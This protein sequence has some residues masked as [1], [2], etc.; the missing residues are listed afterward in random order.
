MRGVIYVPTQVSASRDDRYAT[1]SM[2]SKSGCGEGDSSNKGT[3]ELLPL[4]RARG[5]AIASG[6]GGLRVCLAA[7]G[8]VLE[9]G[10]RTA[11]KQLQA[12]CKGT[13]P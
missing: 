13:D 1:R 8:A 4:S 9:N 2:V 11:A 3:A 6:F 12:A 5:T 7:F 10:L